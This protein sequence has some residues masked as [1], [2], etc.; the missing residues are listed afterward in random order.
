MKES[1][2]GFRELKND[3]SK[4]TITVAVLVM[5]YCMPYDPFLLPL[6]AS[7]DSH[8]ELVLSCLGRS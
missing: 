5:N 4:D 6:W 2:A 3:L 7:S 8:N 1:H